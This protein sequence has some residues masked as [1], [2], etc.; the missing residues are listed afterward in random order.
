MVLSLC[1]STGIVQCILGLL[2]Q[3]DLPHANDEM[4]S[5]PVKVL[6]FHVGCMWAACACTWNMAHMESQG[7]CYLGNTDEHCLQSHMVHRQPASCRR[8]FDYCTH[9]RPI[10]RSAAYGAKCFLS[11]LGH[12]DLAVVFPTHDSNLVLSAPTLSLSNQ[13]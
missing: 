2:P 1:S 11:W 8:A 6:R 3:W 10:A 7:F 13:K 5:Q 12:S 4:G 9:T